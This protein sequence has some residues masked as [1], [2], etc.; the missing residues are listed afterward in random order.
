MCIMMKDSPKEGRYRPP[1]GHF[2]PGILA[3]RWS[4]FAALKDPG[5][6]MLGT[7]YE[8]TARSQFG[9]DKSLELHGEALASLVGC[10]PT[11]FPSHYDLRATILQLHT[12]HNILKIS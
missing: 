6:N 1:V 3:N 9:D 5:F 2:S 4:R 11:G 8:S 10:A 12:S 7:D